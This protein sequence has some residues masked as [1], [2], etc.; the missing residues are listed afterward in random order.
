M[1]SSSLT[2]SKYSVLMSALLSVMASMAV[3]DSI[4]VPRPLDLFDQELEM[5]W[6]QLAQ[7]PATGLEM[8]VELDLDLRPDSPQMMSIL[9]EISLE[10]PDQETRIVPRPVIRRASSNP[11][12]RSVKRELTDIG[13]QI[14]TFIRDFERDRDRLTVP[15]DF[16]ASYV[17]QINSSRQGVGL[18]I[19][20]ERNS[21]SGGTSSLGYRQRAGVGVQIPLLGTQNL[22]LRD[23]HGQIMTRLI[24]L[25]VHYENMQVPG[26]GAFWYKSPYNGLAPSSSVSVEANFR[27]ANRFQPGARFVFVGIYQDGNARYRTIS[28]VYVK[29]RLLRTRAGWISNNEVRTLSIVPR[30]IHQ[31]TNYPGAGDAFFGDQGA[32]D[33]LLS[34]RRRVD[35]TLGVEFLTGR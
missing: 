14:V 31:M 24:P 19:E 23:R 1:K 16:R 25:G 3:A 34:T 35:C 15:R 4:W 33:V 8:P 26:E 5:D 13:T 27:V 17:N 9:E 18:L 29:V 21:A 30:C 7:M 10:D 32:V 22:T 20:V 28:E 2:L 12:L 6:E 11:L